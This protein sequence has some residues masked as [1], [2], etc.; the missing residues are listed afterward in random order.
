MKD[1]T[2]IKA[3][4]E[5]VG[6]WQTENGQDAG[7][8]KIC[9]RDPHPITYFSPTAPPNFIS[10]IFYLS[11]AMFHFGYQRTIQEMDDFAKHADELQ[12]HI[13]RLENDI[14]WQGTPFQQRTEVVVNQ[15]RHELSKVKST[16]YSFTVQL[17]DPEHVFRSMAF[18][19]FVSTWV[20]RFVDPRKKHPSPLVE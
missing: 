15:A 10:D 18:A 4:S 8:E 13:D 19:T 9:L 7:M 14:N 3:T 1:E 20:V 11:L 2:R 12:R 17:L 5:E 16:S 6:T